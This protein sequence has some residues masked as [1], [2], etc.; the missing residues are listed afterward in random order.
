MKAIVQYK[1]G[2]PDDVLEL[3]EI[4]KPVVKEDEVPVR[5]HAAG[6]HTGDWLVVSGLPYLT[7]IVTGLLKPKN[8]V[9]GM[10]AH[11]QWRSKSEIGRL[12]DLKT[13]G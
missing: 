1:Y 7:R 9:P 4:D 3:E 8:M 13:R 2:S 5:V 12:Y 10:N 6:V 11:G